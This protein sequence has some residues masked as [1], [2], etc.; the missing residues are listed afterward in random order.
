MN[1]KTANTV[2]MIWGVGLLYL[3]FN[4]IAQAYGWPFKLPGLAFEKWDRYATALVAV[5]I[6]LVGLVVLAAIGISHARASGAGWRAR[7]PVPFGL[8]DPESGLL[9]VAQLFAFVVLPLMGAGSLFAKFLSGSY[10][11]RAADSGKAVA[12]LKE[13]YV[14][15]GDGVFRY[16]SWGDATPSGNYIYEGGP[17]FWPFWQPVLYCLLWVAT[18]I[19]LA[20]FARAVLHDP[21]GRVAGSGPGSAD[22]PDAQYYVPPT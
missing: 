1:K 22:G 14:V 9:H 6:V 20:L 2:W 8:T 3:T 16:V 21:P 10:C 5:P 12:C 15:T 19:A 18:L 17:D 13:G 7:L 11:R 4:S